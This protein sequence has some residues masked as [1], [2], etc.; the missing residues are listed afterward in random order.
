M[1]CSAS[2]ISYKNSKA[3]NKYLTSY[4]PKKQTKCNTYLDKNNIRLSTSKSLP[5]E[6]SGWI[7]QNLTYIN[8]MVTV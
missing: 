2:Y 6:L 5:A 7:L 8:M 1:K 3:N 4:N